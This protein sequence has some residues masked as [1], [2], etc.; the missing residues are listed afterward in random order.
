MK[1]AY[2][3]I[4]ETEYNL[5]RAMNANT[6]WWTEY[7]GKCG[8]NRLQALVNIDTKLKEMNEKDGYRKKTT[9]KKPAKNYQISCG[10]HENGL[11]VI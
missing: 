11:V 5:E 4:E 2:R 9:G 7:A 1:T 10:L 6:E 3:T 8:Q